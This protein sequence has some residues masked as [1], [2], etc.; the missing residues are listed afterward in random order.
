[1]SQNDIGLVE[2][3]GIA[4]FSVT[5]TEPKFGNDLYIGSI[6]LR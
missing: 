5:S 3:A 2:R 1:M 4:C 6:A